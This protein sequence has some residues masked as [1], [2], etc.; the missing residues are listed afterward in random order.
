MLLEFENIKTIDINNDDSWRNKIFLTF[1][2]DW[3]NDEVIS[4]TLD[5]LERCNIKATIFITHQTKMLDRMVKNSNI[6]LGIHPNFNPLLSGNF[7]YGKN[8]D[9]V[10]KYYMRIVPDA[11][12]VRSHSLTQNEHMLDQFVNHGLRFELNHFIPFS[13]NMELKPFKLWNGLIKAMHFWQDNMQMMF[14]WDWNYEPYSKADGLKIF[15]FHP[16]HLFLNTERIDR[17][18]RAKQHYGEHHK[19][20]DFVN[21]KHYGIC[22]FLLDIVGQIK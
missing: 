8:V 11:L 18:E 2:L 20:K 14:G 16:I 17:Y 4:F 22:N 10:I 9:D 19:L 6:E 3:A 1:D 13:A 15:N 7:E 21:N 12:S 5:I